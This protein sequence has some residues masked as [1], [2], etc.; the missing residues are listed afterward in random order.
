MHFSGLAEPAEC[1]SACQQAESSCRP[2]ACGLWLGSRASGWCVGRALG[3]AWMGAEGARAVLVSVCVSREGLL[4]A[5]GYAMRGQ[6]QWWRCA[7]AGRRHER[8]PS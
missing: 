8:L 1:Q 3:R 6:W 7:S 4:H 5:A 2:A